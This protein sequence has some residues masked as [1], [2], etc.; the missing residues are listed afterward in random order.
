MKHFSC[1]ISIILAF[2]GGLFAGTY[3][4]GDG[5]S[6]NPY[7]IATT[8][9]LVE[10]SNTSGD[11]GSYFIQTA[12]ISFNTDET[13]VDWDGDGTLEH[14]TDGDDTYGFS[15][16]G[17]SS[18][19][20]TGEYDGGGY[21]IDNLY[22][23]R[24]STEYI[25]LFGKTD[26][27]TITNIGLTNVDIT[28]QNNVGG[29][30]GW[31][32]GNT[33]S[34]SYTTGSV[35]GENQGYSFY[36]LYVG[37]IAG[38]N[39]G[40]TISNSYS[41]VSV[42]GYGDIGGLV[43][44]NS[45]STLSKCYAAGS[46]S[47][48]ENTGG[49]VGNSSGSDV[50]DSVWDTETTGQSSSSGGGTGKTTSEMKT[51][52]T[53]TDAGWD[54]AGEIANGTND[55]WDM[56]GT[57]NHGYPFLSWQDIQ[58][59]AT[60]T[61][62]TATGLDEQVDLTWT[63]NTEP[64]LAHYTLYRNTTNDST[65]ATALATI[66]ASNTTY[67]D[68]SVTNETT[69]YYWLT[70]IDVSDN[71]SPQST[72]VQAVPQ[73]TQPPATPTGL[74]ATGR[75]GQVDLTWTANTE[76][77]L[78]QYTIYR[79]TTNDS[80]SASA[81]ATISALNTSYTDNDVI[82]E[83]TYY[84]WLT[85]TD[86]SDNESV[87]S[88]GMQATPADTQPP[89]TP[90]GLIAT[91]LDGQVDLEWTANTESD[92]AHYTLY[93][94]TTND[95]SNATV[96]ETISAPNTTYIDNSVTNETTYY[97]WLTATDQKDNE[98][99]KSAGVQA[100][101]EDTSPPA[102]PIGLSATG[103]DGQVDLAWTANAEADLA[104]YTL[105]RN[106]TNDSASATALTTIAAPTTSYTDNSVTNQTT[107]YYWLT[108]VDN[109]DNESAMS[110]GVQATPVDTQPP[111]T[112]TGLT[113]TGLDGQVDLTWTANTEHD[114]AQYT[115]YRNTTNDSTSA[116]ALATIAAPTTNHTDNS[117]TNDTTYYYWLTATDSSGNESA[118]SLGVPAT[119][120]ISFT[121]TAV[122]PLAAIPGETITLYGTGFTANTGDHQVL[123]GDHAVTPTAAGNH[124]LDVTV[125][126]VS[127]D[128]FGL[129]SLAVALGSDTARWTPGFTIIPPGSGSGVFGSQQVITTAANGARDV[130][131]ADLDKD[132]DLDILSASRDNNTIAW[133]AN[134][135]VGTFGSQQVI[136]TATYGARDV[137]AADLDGDGDL[138]A[139]S[140]S[141]DDNKIAW[142]A[143]DGTGTFSSQQVISTAANGA[144]DVCAADLDRDGDLDVLSAS[145]YDDKIAWYRNDG[146]GAFGSQQVISTNAI[147][148]YDVST[149]DLDGDGDLDVLSA[150]AGDDKIAWYRNDGAGTFG[151]Q[152]VIT[153][154]ADYAT[155]VYAAD[156]DGDGDRDILSASRYDSTIAWYANDGAGT[157]GTQQVITSV[158][159]E[160]FSVYASDLNGDGD[161]D[162]LSASAGDN[163]IAW[164]SNDGMGHFGSQ[165]VLTAA[166]HGARVV[167][168]AD[169]DSDGDL[170]VI[171]ASREDDTIAWYRNE[172][173]NSVGPPAIPMGLTGNGL[174][175]QI[176]LTWLANTAPDLAHYTLYR[177]T[178]NDSTSATALATITAPETT[179]TDTSVTN[180]TTYYYWLTAVDSSG[181]ES[182][183]STGVQ[184][185]PQDTQPTATPT[186][187][188]A[189]GLNG[190]VDLAWTANSES[191]LASYTLYRNTTNDSTNAAVLATVFVPNTT[192]IDS[193]V[194]NETTYHY[195]LT[196]TDSSGNESAQSTGTQAT[197]ADT[198]PP[199]AP[200]DLTAT[201]LNG[202]VDLTWTANTES[203]LAYYLL[204]RNTTNNS[205][206]GQQRQSTIQPSRLLSPSLA[207]EIP[208]QRSVEPSHQSTAGASKRTL[209]TVSSG[210]ETL[211][212]G[213]TERNTAST[214][215]RD[216][217]MAPDSTYTDMAV[218]NDTTYYYWLT[219]VDSSGN[220]SAQSTGAQATPQDTA[221]PATPT[222]LSATGSSSQVDLAWTANTAPDLAQYTLYRHIANDSTSATA[223]ATIIT[224]DTTF[225]DTAVVNDTTYYYWLTATDSSGNESAMSSGV[226]AT[227]DTYFT[228]TAVTPSAAIPG[229]T[230]TLYGTGFTSN[231]GD[232]QILFGDNTVT[233]TAT[234]NQQLDV[235]VPSVPG[236]E[237]GLLSLAV[238]LDSDTARWTPGFTIIP[239]GHS[240]GAFGSQQVIS[241]A[242]DKA[243]SVY[244]ADLDG[245]GDP[246]VLSASENDHKIAWYANDGTGNFGSQQVISTAATRVWDVHAADLDGDGDQDVLSASSVDDII[247]WYANDGTGTFGSQQVITS[248][249]DWA[250][251]VYTA[252]LDGDGD[253]DV[254]SASASDAKIAWYANDGAGHFG[255]Q[256]VISTAAAFANS[257]Y[258][259]DLDGDGDLDVLSASGSD[260]KIA[261]YANDGVGN[262]SAQRVISTAVDAGTSVH[263]ADLDGDGDLDV[264]SA[265]LS[266]D[267]I[268]W[269]TNDGE[270][271]FGSQQVIS[272]AANGASS[273][274]TTDLD[275]DGDLDVLSASFDDDKIAWYANDGTGNFGSQQ[276]ISTAANGASSVYTTD[277][278]GDGDMDV[279]S[280]SYDDDKIAWYRNETPSSVGSPATPTSLTARGLNGQ[281]DLAWTANSE[282]D[283]A[284]YLL[285]RNTTDDSTMGQ[286]GQSAMQPSRLLTPSLA[287]EVQGRSGV[288]PA[289]QSKTGTKGRSLST[290]ASTRDDI[291]NGATVGSITSATVL[292]TIMAPDTTYAD[293]AVVNDTT[294]Y[295]WL[296]AV[297]SSGN[298]SAMS[299]GVQAT[300]R[301]PTVSTQVTAVTP[302][303]AIPGHTITIYGTIFTANPEDHQVLF[304][305]T[306]V[307]PA[308]AGNQQLQV[309]VPTVSGDEFGLMSLAVALG[310]DTARWTPGFTIIPPGG[311]PGRFGSQQVITTAADGTQDVYAAGLDGDGDLD[312]LSANISD[313]EIAW[314]ANDGAGNFGN[315]QHIVVM[316]SANSV[317]AADL[318]G[319]G[320]MDVLSAGDRKVAWYANDGA[321][322]FGVQQVITSAA[323]GAQDVHTADLNGDG[324]LDVLSASASE[325]DTKIA[326]Y[327]NDGAGNF[328]GQQIIS[329]AVVWP[330][331]VY[332]ADLDGDGDQDVLSASEEDDKFAWYANDG[333]GHFGTQQVISTAANGAR[334]VYAADLD[335]DGDQ[336]VISASE[337][338]SKIAWYANDGSGNFGGQ[339]LLT[340]EVDEYT[341][342]SV[343]A[344][345]LDGDG[346]QDVLSA[347]RVDGIAWH[348]NNGAGEFEP[349]QTITFNVEYATSVYASDLDG[350]GDQDVLSASTGDD[351]I[352]WYRNETPNDSTTTIGP[353]STIPK[354]YA[355]FHNYPNPFNPVTTLKYALPKD[356]KVHLSVYDITGRKVAT[357]V[358]DQQQAG[359]HEVQ[360]HGTNDLGQSVSTGVYFYR[361]VAGD[362]VDVKKM[363]YMK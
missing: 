205:I 103:L 313:Y 236:D 117:V 274:Y 230:I 59:P 10:L 221:P 177:N 185:T 229:E 245:D 334:D 55:Y 34:Y 75:D 44:N 301:L 25:A 209:S 308:A 118:M 109:S 330:K 81:L 111:A 123:F 291:S 200:T 94:N 69:Y 198:Q 127:E 227:P 157:F 63:A 125:P 71:E 67:T 352:A 296:T 183:Q 298:E 309:T 281:V 147:K 246:D 357:L 210:R 262:F 174:N 260:D 197:P 85:A 253:L 358:Q 113:A 137:H 116:T 132:G 222:G 232:H 271:N 259:A 191:D 290:V 239:P 120:V 22:I 35:H 65:S 6:G 332:T 315:Q 93:R 136:S 285:Y 159:N 52:S 203:D 50:Y 134:D 128:D 5:S 48:T 163:T 14:G 124:Q 223:F 317:Q 363:V 342:V 180:E 20:F 182:A 238:A 88:D 15:P 213:A 277:L 188:T 138:D 54:F 337:D 158:T 7:Q 162:V 328:G 146:T 219:A 336:D 220:E 184:A 119:P 73:D 17:T 318:D 247:A 80:T 56:D 346:D 241:L 57:I 179:Y 263:A 304:G 37:G 338:D 72:G 331:S 135:G 235:T 322:N 212:H 286:Q 156:L 122:T 288:I 231:P 321:G 83:T 21:I 269:Y 327:A 92:L 12:D 18:T 206:T 192:Y 323:D 91:G 225:T 344:I 133:Y 98:S 306:A 319:D 295:Y 76:S 314:Y 316:D 359:W 149:A 161:R 66:A 115:L 355:L 175:E 99:A 140:A 84:Y 252:D 151:S 249:A 178:V 343:C 351:K 121:I 244:T 169:L 208:G 89:A 96:L 268:A 193:S 36:G 226:Q 181:Y 32:N 102:A 335:G 242:A 1:T 360:W 276:I 251:S 349:R 278:D 250:T 141:F 8:S 49:L 283:L 345:D 19:E 41:I 275:G 108:A 199:T 312:V 287:G 4:G 154:A 170:D 79:N 214:S 329:T 234:G 155:S 248:N 90:T 303:A 272:T 104:Q 42:S 254:L 255:S 51:Q 86:S 187:L 153:T 168:A 204:Y 218:I 9:D 31:H 186:G 265:S 261:W 100:T 130:E 302:N 95:A 40:G 267:K 195:W 16:I 145:Y 87:M 101:P 105:Y 347:S 33:V 341:A 211:Q 228:I 26:A 326:W 53:F 142:Y 353:N 129:L 165:H 2:A 194:T 270:G 216:T 324:H 3:S 348:A 58:P 126:P 110:D 264:L 164:Y 27:T 74:S 233:P 131:T 112:P 190:Q 106:T 300:P 294:Y 196:A 64:D 258:T 78:T 237:F 11:W 350:D 39:N 143:N 297:D 207:G 279:L 152:Q 354:E 160:A 13:Q 114:L 70:A 45:F 243:R 43:G 293:T 189:T 38:T 201:G 176:E 61:G 282:P 215:V 144:R 172:T 333:T 224:P 148:A 97:Y 107:Y 311:G 339:Q 305:D 292:D 82:N 325:G 273:V 47:G 171:S 217:I 77:D 46:V 23:N 173:A 340:A 320:D 29:L 307:T 356:T 139:L 284:Y 310:S 299:A 202:Q 256:Q 30:V 150:S 289:R 166:A 28:G 60:P 167:Y 361:I 240:S 62:L 257:V 280:A 24:P 362:F 68:N 266:D